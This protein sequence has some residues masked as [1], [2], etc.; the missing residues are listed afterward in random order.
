MIGWVVDQAR[1]LPAMGLPA[2]TVP[3]QTGCVISFL[4][5]SDQADTATMRGTYERFAAVPGTAPAAP[6]YL[7]SNP[8]TG[9]IG[10]IAPGSANLGS[11]VPDIKMEHAGL[12][13]ALAGAGCA[14][15]GTLRI[16]AGPDLGPFVLP[17]GNYH[18]YDYAL[19]WANLR[20]DF[21]ARAGAWQTRR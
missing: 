20:R 3:A 17:G 5:F 2:C 11:I 13:P 10:G 9:G 16:G 14:P 12:V 21:A 15:D 4:S 18:V 1:D 6:Q 19:F 7:C 8:L